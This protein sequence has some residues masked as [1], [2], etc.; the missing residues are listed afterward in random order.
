MC[1]SGASKKARK[2]AHFSRAYYQRWNNGETD[3][4]RGWLRV[5][6][7]VSNIIDYFTLLYLQTLTTHARF[8]SVFSQLLYLQNL[9]F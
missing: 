7:C 2:V 6:A 3:G 5:N 8:P 1:V 4:N 9:L